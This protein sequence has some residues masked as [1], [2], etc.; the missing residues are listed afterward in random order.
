LAKKLMNSKSTRNDKCMSK[1][2]EINEQE[3]TQE[4][5]DT[6]ETPGDAG[7]S[8]AEQAHENQAQEQAEESTEQKLTRELAEAKDKHLRL[9]SE[10]ENFRR[11]TAKERLDLIATANADLILSLLPV[12]DDFERAQKAAEG[13]PALEAQQ[14]GMNLIYHKLMKEL[15]QKGLKPMDDLIGSK[16]DAEVHEA[17]SQIPA[18]EEKLKNRIVDVVEK[19]YY[20]KEKVIRYAKVVIGT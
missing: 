14:E 3:P 15:S 17:I 2:E 7:Q 18:P 12:V 4:S 16:F 8:P 9:Y 1:K 13:D 6:V 20:L 19:G 5:T 10:F 11:R